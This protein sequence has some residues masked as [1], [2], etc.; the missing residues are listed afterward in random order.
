MG[1]SNSALGVARLYGRGRKGPGGGHGDGR[2]GAEKTG[3]RE[4]GVAMHGVWR[5]EE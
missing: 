2:R 4:Q 1:D 3:M 5:K